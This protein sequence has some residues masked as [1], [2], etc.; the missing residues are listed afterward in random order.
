MDITKLLAK[1]TQNDPEKEKAQLDEF[2]S[3]RLQKDPSAVLKANTLKA[4]QEASETPIGKLLG[5][6]PLSP[7][8]QQ[9]YS[10]N[11]DPDIEEAMSRGMQMGLG[12]GSISK[13][14]SAA[15]KA[16][17]DKKANLKRLEELYS[18]RFSTGPEATRLGRQIVKEKD[19]LLKLEG[20]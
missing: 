12:M 13:G 20:K 9:F 11:V 3:S 10:E 15:A 14:A 2:L 19:A 18:S 17:A 6:S 5:V 1:L 16:L 4:R 8:E 7:E